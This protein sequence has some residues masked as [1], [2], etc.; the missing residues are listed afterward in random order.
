MT[1]I[2]RL[3]EY[4]D[5]KGIAPTSF[6]KELGISNGYM[7]KML[8]RKANIGSNILG[9]IVEYC[10]DL[11]IEWLLVGSNQMIKTKSIEN[12][13]FPE[14]QNETKSI[15][16]LTDHNGKEKGKK[17]GNKPKVQKNL[18]KEY[19]TYE[20]TQPEHL[21][22]KEESERYYKCQAC[23]QK[24]RIIEAQ[25]VTIEAQK[26]ELQKAEL[27]INLLTEKSSDLNKQT[28]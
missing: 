2:E 18:P 5:F 27:L 7:G 23:E 15:N 13:T 11:N 21:S 25:N 28:G 24:E 19:T 10:P 4:F 22:A 8:R 20:S 3:Y 6:E 17:K 16:N 14:S 12:L 26:G 1:A 9:K